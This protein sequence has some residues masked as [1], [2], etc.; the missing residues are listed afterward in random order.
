MPDALAAGLAMPG[1]PWLLAAALLAGVV[2]GF[3][4]FGAAL[5]FMPLAT[6]F[7]A[8]AFAVA[9][10]AL[11]ATG[12]VFSVLP[13]AL[14]E[15]DRRAASVMLGAAIVAL[16]L[17]VWVLRMSDPVALRWAVSAVVLITLLALVTGWRYKQTPG[18]P[19]WLGVGGAVGFLGG[20]VGLNG[21]A[22]VLFQLAGQG[23][24]AR[25]RANS[26]VVLTLSSLGI[27]LAM[28]LQGAVPTGAIIAGL[29]MFPVYALGGV[30]GRQLFDPAREDLYRRAAY[31][32]IGAAGLI[33]L[34]LFT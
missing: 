29:I 9:S 18:I 1:L 21:P 32:I 13:Q 12:S 33:G 22:L 8:P 7:V 11:A 16:P 25:V 2:Y 14:R 30:I 5:I 3:A 19:A 26:I 23:R 27:L 10:F 24:A 6:I 17:G 34:P 4:G 15:A 31:G 20:S 28:L